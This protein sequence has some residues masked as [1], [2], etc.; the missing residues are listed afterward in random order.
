MRFEVPQFI[1]VQDKI[2][3]GMTLQQFLFVGGGAGIAIVAYRTLP[4][5][6]NLIVA[7]AGGGAGAALAF[8]KYNGRPLINTIE[9]LF[10]YKIVNTSRLYI[11]QQRTQKKGVAVKDLAAETDKTLSQAQQA[12]AKSSSKKP[13]KEERKG[14]INDD[15]VLTELELKDLAWS[16]DIL[17]KKNQ[18][19]GL[20]HD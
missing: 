9:A 4:P 20:L 19:S 6:V 17:E 16:L 7:A 3:A 13:Q 2:I 14:I 12:Q 10:F 11:W 8:A 1:D 18:N 5:L 15:G